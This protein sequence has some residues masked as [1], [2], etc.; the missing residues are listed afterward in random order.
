MRGNRRD[1]SRS[2]AAFLPLVEDRASYYNN[3]TSF[4]FALLIGTLLNVIL[5]AFLNVAIDLEDPFD[6]QG[7]LPSCHHVFSLF[8]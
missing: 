6:N 4:S 5:V 8:G 1:N 7:A 2:R 3:T